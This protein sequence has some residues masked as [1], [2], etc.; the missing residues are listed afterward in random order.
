M[1][2][3]VSKCGASWDVLNSRGIVCFSSSSM[4]VAVAWLNEH[5]NSLCRGRRS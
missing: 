4:A 1:K 5:W 3:Y 2:P